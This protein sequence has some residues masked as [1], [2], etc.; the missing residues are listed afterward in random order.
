MKKHR[1][2]AG[3]YA[4][5]PKSDPRIKMGVSHCQ[6]ADRKEW[7]KGKAKYK[8][9]ECP[10]LQKK[11]S[12]NGCRCMQTGTCNKKIR[13]NAMPMPAGLGDTRGTTYHG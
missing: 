1:Y 11:I 4:Q 12:W 3:H 10:M 13:C 7:K 6:W 9:V 5:K 8:M 2:H